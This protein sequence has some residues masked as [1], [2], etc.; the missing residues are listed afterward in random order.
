MIQRIL[1]GVLGAIIT[2][3]TFGFLMLREADHTS[4]PQREVP[5]KDS[6]SL[7]PDQNQPIARNSLIGTWS[8]KESWG[9][10]HTITRNADGSFLGRVNVNIFP[11]GVEKVKRERWS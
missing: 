11:G 2:A 9:T 7:S 6:K 3:A 4:D 5:Q 1:Y 8:G 10:T